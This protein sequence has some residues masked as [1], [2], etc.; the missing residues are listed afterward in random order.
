LTFRVHATDAD[1]DVITLTA[2]NAPTNSSF[3]DSGNGAVRL[4]LIRATL[5]QGHI[6]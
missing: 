3:A 4:A 1:G 2:T 6:M 5:S